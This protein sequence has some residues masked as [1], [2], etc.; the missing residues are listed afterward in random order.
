[1]RF[2]GDDA[3]TNLEPASLAFAG[4]ERLTP[5]Q[6]AVSDRFTQLGFHSGPLEASA[7]KAVV[8]AFSYGVAT[9][10][11]AAVGRWCHGHLTADPDAR[12]LL[13]CADRNRDLHALRDGL[14]AALAPG[15]GPEVADGVVVE[16]GTPLL[17]QPLVSAAAG[18]LALSEGD[19]ESA[20]LGALLM[21][22]YHS[23]ADLLSASRLDAWLRDRV[24]R[25]CEARELQQLLGN[26]PESVAAAAQRLA[27]LLASARE[28]RDRGRANARQWASRFSELTLAAGHPGPRPANSAE[29][30]AWQR[31][32]AALEEF[33][34]LDAVLPPL[35]AYEA[36]TRFEGLLRRAQHQAAT[37]DAPV[38]LTHALTDPVV[39]YDGIWVMGAGEAQ[40]PEPPRPNPYLPF[41]VQRRAGLPEAS[42]R[43]RLTSARALQF[44]WQRSASELVFSHPRADADLH[45]APSPLIE[46]PIESLDVR[47]EA[48]LDVGVAKPATVE[49]SLPPVDRTQRLRAG[50]RLPELQRDCPFRAQA[51]LRFGAKE[52][53]APRVGIDPRLRGQLL[54]RSLDELWQRIGSS[55]KLTSR[56]TSGWSAEIDAAVATAFSTFDPE[57]R[58][59]PSARELARERDRCRELLAQT[60]ELESARGVDFSVADR[61]V[62]RDW[63]V[64]G[65]TLGLRIDRVD[66]LDDGSL[67]VID[68]KTG[69]ASK[70]DLLADEPRPVQLLAYLD[71][72]EQGSGGNEVVSLS[73][74]KLVPGQVEFR[75][76]EDGRAG[77]PVGRRAMKPE[78]PWPEQT[79]L[80]RRDVQQLVERHLAGEAE[81]KPL[82]GACDHCALPGLCRIDS[83]ALAETLEADD[84]DGDAA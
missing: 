32:Q 30:Q 77:L 59:V 18:L 33:A 55:A 19:I 21:S 49:R 53:P 42:A 84:D 70:I 45:V 8:H 71:A 46:V 9:D 73:L 27:T 65:V 62:K 66:R 17:R 56:P 80:W 22:P 25:Q 2:A 58:V 3:I 5:R 72:L 60:L 37:G 14:V 40:W 50:S 82:R 81:V 79:E 47:H 24:P 69:A 11:V 12:L 4:F 6:L 78:R 13:V 1:S 64:A 75:A 54:H 38:T 51:E 61:E 44:A 36:R 23:L 28:L 16:G 26:A 48:W 39:G 41:T 67:A 34:S 7:P 63:R 20:K 52:L 57:T 31:W 74:L 29:L 83:Q 15:A 76:I 10:E 68:Y 35:S 43:G